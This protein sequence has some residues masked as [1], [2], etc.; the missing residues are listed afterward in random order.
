MVSSAPAGTSRIALTTDPDVRVAGVVE[1]EE[2]GFDVLGAAG[3]DVET[4][5]D[6]NLGGRYLVPDAGERGSIHDDP[7]LDRDDL[8]R[9]DRV[10]REEPPA[11]DRARAL[12]GLGT[13]PATDGR[14]AVSP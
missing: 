13:E 3:C 12:L 9:A 6:L 14:G 2:V 7:A 11:L 8:T 10:T 4:I 1:A 5:L